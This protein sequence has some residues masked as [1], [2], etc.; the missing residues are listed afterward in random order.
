MKT[1]TQ[2]IKEW[3][4]KNGIPVSQS[5]TSRDI[6][7]DDPVFWGSPGAVRTLLRLKVIPGLDNYTPI[8]V[9]GF[10]K[11]TLSASTSTTKP[12]L[13]QQTPA[14]VLSIDD[15]REMYDI[16]T[17][18]MNALDSIKEG[19]FWKEGDFN[20]RFLNGKTGYR[21]ILESS[22]AQN[23]RGKA[24]GGQIYYSHPTSMRQAKDG[25]YLL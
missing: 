1:K 7:D 17:I 21:S 19:Q 24:T 10:N 8:P 12:T 9:G 18:V 6:F 23:Y 22:I 16:K 4:D 13:K 20:R 11:K 2:L 5:Q 14:E 25:G 15:L 3:V